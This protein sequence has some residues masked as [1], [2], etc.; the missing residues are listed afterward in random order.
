MEQK[1]RQLVEK[2]LGRDFLLAAETYGM[3]M[4]KACALQGA[5]ENVQSSLERI[6]TVGFCKGA[7]YYRDGLWHDLSKDY[8]P[9]DRMI[10]CRAENGSLYVAKCVKGKNGSLQFKDYDGEKVPRPARW[11]LPPEDEKD[12]S[13]GK[14]IPIKK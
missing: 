9:L 11:L 12:A 8:P 7:E 1:E 10:L 3:N 2:I 6:A 5:S 4:R 14:T 13:K